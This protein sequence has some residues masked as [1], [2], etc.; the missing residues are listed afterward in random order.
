MNV[1][2]L[3]MALMALS[4]TAPA[5][6][7]AYDAPGDCPSR[8][9]FAAA[10]SARGAELA[11]ADPTADDRVMVVSINKEGDGYGGAFHVRD[12]RGATGKR[13]VHGRSCTEVADALAVVTAIALR[14][15]E[16]E[17]G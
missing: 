3:L 5:A 8:A 1:S 15:G 11:A 9:Q 16:A 13:E 10:V 17:A 14:P 4:T 12:S 6:R 7:L 2:V